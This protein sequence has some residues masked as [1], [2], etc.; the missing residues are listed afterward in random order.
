MSKGR[1]SNRRPL[2][3]AVLASF[4]AASALAAKSQPTALELPEIKTWSLDN[5]LQ[6]S[7]LGVHKAPVVAV[8]VWYHVGSK[9]ERRDRGGSAHMFEHMLFKGTTHVRPEDHARFLNQVG[10][11][12]NAFTTQDTTAYHQQMPKEYL[13]F[14][15]KLE[16]E[17]MRSL[18]LRKD[19]I[20]T[21][22]EVVKEEYR[23]RYENSPIGK[24]LKTF[25]ETAYT[26]HPYGALAIGTKQTLDAT[27]QEY[28]QSF[29]DTYYVPNNAMLV[30]VGDV[31]ED[32]AKNCAETAFG[33]IPKGKTPPRPADDLA[34]PKQTELRRKVV[35]PQQI[36]IILGGY[37]V[38]AAKH[39]DMAAL[40]VASK[41]LSDGDSSRM[42]K[43]LVRKDKTAVAAAGQL[44]SLEHPGMF[45]IFGVY[46]Q[47]ENGD[48]VESALIDEIE[49]LRKSPP[50]AKEVQ[51]AKN[52]LL[53]DFAFG[54][55]GVDGLANQIGFSWINT[56]DPSFFL[57]S[58]AKYDA[59]TAKDVQRVAKEYL[60][61][62][63]LTIVVIPP[64]AQGGS[65]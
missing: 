47:A 5:G 59:V 11:T 53:A 37:H 45:I 28:L 4:A 14:A 39:D 40:Q 17:R 54:L 29:Y 61:K 19:M 46:L 9:E 13:Q 10:G 2:L 18:L 48:K 21:E 34:E 49:K 16:A 55:E 3:I 20:D 43:R 1:I 15:C 24:G 25:F 38:P 30:I 51:K 41:I 44:F 22:R 32:E 8:H 52:Q 7:Y 56:G 23:L 27:D 31:T 57:G 50:S 64:M 6:V 62:D 63:N 36:G 65:K 60:S 58:M 35:G 26:R 42:N 33:E 12:V